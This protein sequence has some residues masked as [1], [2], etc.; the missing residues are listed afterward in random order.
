MTKVEQAEKDQEWMLKVPKD[1]SDYNLLTV[2]G[3]IL[4]NLTFYISSIYLV[5][6][7]QWENKCISLS[8]LPMD[9][10]RLAQWE[11]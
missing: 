1:N 11:N 3:S 10:V 8:A 7:A 6:V 5:I 9:R 2:S 4:F